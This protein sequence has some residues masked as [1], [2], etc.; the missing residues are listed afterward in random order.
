[1]QVGAHTRPRSRTRATSSH[2]RSHSDELHFVKGLSS[3]HPL[4]DQLELPLLPLIV[5]GLEPRRVPSEEEAKLIETCF[6]KQVLG[7]VRARPSI[8]RSSVRSLRAARRRWGS[9]VPTPPT[10]AWVSQWVRKW[11]GRISRTC[12]DQISI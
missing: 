2:R 12:F 7:E 5:L 1:M 10:K 6:S 3:D 8:L 4:Y 11:S 9:E